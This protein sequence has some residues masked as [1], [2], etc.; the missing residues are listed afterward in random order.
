MIKMNSTIGSL[1]TQILTECRCLFPYMR[2]QELLVELIPMVSKYSPEDLRKVLE[3]E[4]S[5]ID[6]IRDSMEMCKKELDLDM[7][8]FVINELVSFN[9]L[10]RFIDDMGCDEEEEEYVDQRMVMVAKM[11]SWFGSLQDLEMYI[12]E[13]VYLLLEEKQEEIVE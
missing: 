1:N 9:G 5:I 11:V 3:N 12:S 7:S 6:S 13:L 10:L 8:I 4:N 2:Y